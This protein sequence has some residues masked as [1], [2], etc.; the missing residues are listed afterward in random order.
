MFD[1][2]ELYKKYKSK[3]ELLGIEDKLEVYIESKDRI[4]LINVLDNESDGSI[5]VPNFIT[6]IEIGAFEGCRFT[7]VTI[8]NKI[9]D[10]DLS[11]AFTMMESEELKIK[12][13]NPQYIVDMSDM[14]SDC[15]RLKKVEM[16]SMDTSKLTDMSY[17]FSGCYNLTDVN[18][19]G[20]NTSKVEDMSYMFYGCS[21]LRALRI[22]GLDIRNVKDMCYMFCGCKNLRLRDIDINIDELGID[23]VKNKV[24]VFKKCIRLN[25]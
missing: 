21:K 1:L 15:K 23:S 24:G 8:D 20:L 4:V 11:G 9:G 13:K 2:L 18:I 5:V 12:I 14:V 19:S 3:I 10:M 7:E 16:I 22:Q 17:M 25:M 6:Y